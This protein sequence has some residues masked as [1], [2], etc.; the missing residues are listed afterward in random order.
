[1]LRNFIVSSPC[2]EFVVALRT[3]HDLLESVKPPSA[4]IP[5]PTSTSNDPLRNRQ[6]NRAFFRPRTRSYFFTATPHVA[7]A[8]GAS[9]RAHSGIVRPDLSPHTF[10]LPGPAPAATP[11][12]PSRWAGDFFPA[13]RQ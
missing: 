4:E 5:V 7:K 1:M 10:S 8:R 13:P 9:H 12:A 3:G 11:A 6:V 2:F